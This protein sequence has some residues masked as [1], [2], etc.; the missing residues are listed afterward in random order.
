MT[1][2]KPT[3]KETLTLVVSLGIWMTVTALFV[4]IRPEHI[5]M[6]VLIAVL[7]LAGSFTRKLVVA[8][9]PFA[10]FGISYDWMR[11]IPNYEVNPIDVQGLYEAEK[12]LFGIATAAHGILTPN[13]YFH[14]H[15]CPAMD[16][17]AGIFYLCWVPVPILFGLG[18]YFARQR[19]VYLRFALVFLF[20]NLIGFAGYYIHPAAPPWYVMKYGFEVILHTPGDVAGLGRFDEMTGL[21]VFNGLYARNANVFAAVPSLHSAYMV[22][23]FYYSLKAQ[24]S[25]W[26]RGLFAVIMTGIWFTAIYSGHHYIIDAILG[27]SCAVAGILVF[28]YILMKIPVFHRFID[29]YTQYIA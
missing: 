28:E 16:F 29:R 13:E 9:L 1:V 3:H 17:M 15:H 12:Q 25:N 8:L 22:V 11:I 18:L 21:S 26:L 4:G 7:F 19:A 20:V 23:A 14:L 5:G 2:N 10:I 6:G 27:A 24:C